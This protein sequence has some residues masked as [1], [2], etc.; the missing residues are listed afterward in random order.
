MAAQSKN[1]GFACE[2]KRVLMEAMIV[3]LVGLGLGLG[4]NF[5]S[6]RGLS[7]TRDYFPSAPPSPEQ[8]PADSGL[9]NRKASDQ[10]AGADAAAHEPMADLLASQGLQA[11]SDE[12]AEQ[13]FHDPL[14]E[15]DAIIFVDAR[16]DRHYQE[17]HIPGAFQLDRYYPENYISV[18]LPVCLQA[19]KVV[20]YCNGGTCEDSALA[21]LFLI[22]LGVPRERVYVYKEGM[23]G[24]VAQERM[25]EVGA[26]LSGVQ[27]KAAP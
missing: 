21:A 3:A 2:L 24:W 26:R 23:A 22:D 7:L 13:W 4:A 20:V 19:S 8:A 16:D 12:E 14:R 15:L 17:G 5:I 1:S 27:R 6:P 25:I 9:E 11:V 10:L 18:V